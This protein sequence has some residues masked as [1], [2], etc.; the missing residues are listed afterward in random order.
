MLPS[1]LTPFTSAG[2]LVRMI[3][4]PFIKTAREHRGI[5]Q[6]QLAEQAGVR[7]VTVWRWENGRTKRLDHQTAERLAAALG[8]RAVELFIHVPE[9]AMP[10]TG[11]GETHAD[12]TAAVEGS[13]VGAHQGV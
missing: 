12:R 1:L 3:N 8:V 13:P 6:A 2:S 10:S 7:E 5:S 9:A 4:G 11:R